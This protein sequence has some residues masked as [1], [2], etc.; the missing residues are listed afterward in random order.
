MSGTIP[1]QLPAQTEQTP[2][3]PTQLCVSILLA[4]RLQVL[5]A[6]TGGESVTAVDQ[7]RAQ[8]PTMVPPEGLLPDDPFPP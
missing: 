7:I 8:D 1:V 3:V 6:R 5:L 4:D 2:L